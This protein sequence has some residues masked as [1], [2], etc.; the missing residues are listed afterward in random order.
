MDQESSWSVIEQERRRLADLLESRDTRDW[1]RPS[2][3]AGW[4]IRDVAAH[5]ALASKPPSVGQMLVEG[6]RARGRFHTLNH[7]SAVRHADRLGARLVTE[8][9]EHAGSRR[10]PPVTSYRNTL[11]DVLVH[12]QDIAIPLELDHPM[13]VEAGRAGAQRVWTMG[14]PFWARRRLRPFRLA[15]TDTDW[16]AGEGA[17]VQGPIAALLLLLTGRTARLDSL[18]GSGADRLRQQVGA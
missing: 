17:L 5:V 2:L 14:W 13:P 4:R 15:A 18:S 8:L 1:D 16:T 11:F 9:R 7:D 6:A 10:L 3:C 12:A